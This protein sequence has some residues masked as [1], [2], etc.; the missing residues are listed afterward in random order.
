MRRKAVIDTGPFVAFIDRRDSH[1]ERVKS[2][3]QDNLSTLELYTTLAVLTEVT[4]LLDF[5]TIA[6]V[7]FLKWIS[8]G[9]ITIVDIQL[10]DLARLITQTE[11]YADIPMDF[12]EASLVLV[13][14]KLK[15]RYVVSVDSD[16]YI[17]R[18]LSKG[19][20]E[21]MIDLS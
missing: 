2:F 21:N 10:E 7:D 13:A 20:L 8:R 5:N 18:T 3:F 15:L 17:Y 9:N 16:F 19:Y 14:E 11:T 4:H 1:H 6:Q 12:A